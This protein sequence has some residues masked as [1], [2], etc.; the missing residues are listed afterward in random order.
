MHI[1][2]KF[3]QAIKICSHSLRKKNAD[4]S[5]CLLFWKSLHH[6]N[7]LLVTSPAVWHTCD[8]RSSWASDMLFVIIIFL[9][10][11]FSDWQKHWKFNDILEEIFLA[12]LCQIV[13]TFTLLPLKP[14]NINW[15]SDSLQKKIKLLSFYWWG[16]AN[17][18][19]SY[20]FSLTLHYQMKPLKPSLHGILLDSLL[21]NYCKVVKV[22]EWL[23]FY[24]LIADCRL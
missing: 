5:F 22:S 3:T 17:T 14:M 21:W 12:F 16:L 7:L 4:Y 8:G 11:L 18:V 23:L 6:L 13:L 2:Y 9:F 10:W 1:F 24:C 15:I 20:F 19:N